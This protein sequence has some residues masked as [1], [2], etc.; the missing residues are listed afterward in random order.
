MHGVEVKVKDGAF[1]RAH[2]GG[3]LEPMCP[4]RQKELESRYFK[5]QKELAV[6]G[7]RMGWGGDC[8]RD[9]S[10]KSRRSRCAPQGGHFRPFGFS[11]VPR[12]AVQSELC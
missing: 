8:G 6:S 9:S 3:A 4:N 12:L 1:G 2:F 10:K 11:V 7:T 5:I